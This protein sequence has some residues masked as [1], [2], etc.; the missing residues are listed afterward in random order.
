MLRLCPTLQAAAADSHMFL[1]PGGE[2]R[3]ATSTLGRLC[4]KGVPTLI[5]EETDT[6]GHRTD[7]L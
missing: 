7:R 5:T 1:Q 3:S 4:S 2:L 6:L